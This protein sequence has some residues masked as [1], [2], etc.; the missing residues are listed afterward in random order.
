MPSPGPADAP[1]TT[2]SSPP[3]GPDS[4]SPGLHQGDIDQRAVWRQVEAETA[5]VVVIDL[6][7]RAILTGRMMNGAGERYAFIV[8]ESPLDRLFPRAD[9]WVRRW[10]QELPGEAS[11]L[12][13][14]KLS[15]RHWTYFWRLGPKVAMLAA[16]R[17][18]YGRGAVAA[19]DAATIQ[20]LCEHWLAPELHAMAEG[21]ALQKRLQRVDTRTRAATRR[22]LRGA[23]AVIALAIACGLWL[24]AGGASA[25]PPD[26]GAPTA[27]ELERLAR[28]SD[29]AL[30]R[31]L[32]R[33]LAERNL[34]QAQLKLDDHLFLGH[35]AQA[36][37]LGEGG[38]VVAHAGL[39][40]PVAASQPLPAAASAALGTGLRR[41]ALRQA[42]TPLGELL[43]VPR[44]PAPT[45]AALQ[46]GDGWPD[47]AKRVAGG[48]LAAA[49]LLSAARLWRHLRKR[50]A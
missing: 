38:V 8:P 29:E 30:Q 2:S 31:S 49:G 16:V 9:A 5:R 6:E 28:L 11:A 15:P 1:I 35:Y 37:V 47:T 26:P 23:L 13:V 33:A 22:E 4:V 14:H 3:A 42:D 40:T 18:R 24:A 34:M 48:L 36:V 43:L 25:P 12:V 46:E 19:G 10:T 21:R 17:H 50:L 32:V 41:V 45:A 7:R 27:A 20:L 44:P 39:A